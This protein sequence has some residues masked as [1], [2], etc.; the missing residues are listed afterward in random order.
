MGVE[1]QWFQ[2][3]GKSSLGTC[4]VA[5]LSL[6]KGAG[7]CVSTQPL[8]E[9]W[10]ADNELLKAFGFPIGGEVINV[11]AQYVINPGGVLRGLETKGPPSPPFGCFFF[12]TGRLWCRTHY[13]DNYI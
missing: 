9:C 4:T 11:L 1:Q 10:A 2:N 8:D 3:G 5:W 7:F 13:I 12:F 6:Q